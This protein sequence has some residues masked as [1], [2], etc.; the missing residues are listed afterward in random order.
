VRQMQRRALEVQL[1]AAEEYEPVEVAVDLRAITA[2]SLVVA[3]AKD[4]PDFRLIAAELAGLLPSGWSNCPGPG[5]C[6]RWNGRGT[7]RDAGR[8][9]TGDS[10]PGRVSSGR[11]EPV[12]PAEASP[13]GRSQSRLACSW[14]SA[15]FRRVDSLSN[16]ILSIMVGR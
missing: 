3:G 6:P 8:L 14:T 15:H 4:L 10:P 1:A 2:P 12:P 13:A 16:R 11:P 5:T 7:V 9:P